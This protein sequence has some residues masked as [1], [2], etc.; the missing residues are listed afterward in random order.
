MLGPVTELPSVAEAAVRISEVARLTPVLPS[1]WLSSTLDAPV[2]CKL[3][4]LQVTGSFKIRGAANKILALPADAAERGVVT[5]S[6]GNHG[7]AVV[8]VSQQRGIPCWV[9]VPETAA[10][11]KRAALQDLGASVVVAGQDAV[12]AERLARARAQD[13][14]RTYVSPYNDLEVVAGQGTVGLELTQQAPPLDVVLV[15]VGGG[16]LVAGVASAMKQA[17]PSVEVVGCSP[18]RSPALHRSVAAGR[19]IEEPTSET[20][21]DATAGGVEAGAVTLDL[22]A[23]LV[24]SWWDV[25]EHDIRSA[26]VRF[27][28]EERLLIEGAAAVPVAALLRH[29]D[30]LRGRSVGVVICGGN[31]ALTRLAELVTAENR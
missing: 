2:L 6:T 17:W 30:E 8:T 20:I 21:S 22:C 24:D 10:A 15:A 31:L 16:G 19:L 27:L 5:A 7:L 14:G 28:E 11:S 9:H 29:R 26:L 12:D 13:E 25:E 18:A 3:E 4:N 23:E 1:A